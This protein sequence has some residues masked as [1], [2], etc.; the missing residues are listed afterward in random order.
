M[1]RILKKKIRMKKIQ[2]KFNKF[3]EMDEGHID[4]LLT[5]DPL[6]QQRQ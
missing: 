1:A 3:G 6:Q 5:N 4:D 2:I